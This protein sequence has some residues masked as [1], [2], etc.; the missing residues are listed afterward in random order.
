MGERGKRFERWVFGV[1]VGRRAKCAPMC[2]GCGGQS[3]LGPRLAKS[4]GS[5]WEQRMTFL[6]FPRT[7]IFSAY[8][9]FPLEPLWI[10]CQAPATLQFPSVGGA[11]WGGGEKRQPME[12]EDAARALRKSLRGCKNPPHEAAPLLTK[13]LKWTEGL[14]GHFRIGTSLHFP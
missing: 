5:T 13:A 8:P 4:T 1:T 2:L 3:A 7:D 14:L 12:R 6:P 10:P 11:E 9:L